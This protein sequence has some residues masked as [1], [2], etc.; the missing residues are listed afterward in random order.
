M[1]LGTRNTSETCTII[2]YGVPRLFALPRREGGRPGAR[3]LS[4]CLCVC[5]A[6]LLVI[7]LPLF[8][9]SFSLYLAWQ[10]IY[11]FIGLFLSVS[12]S[13]SLLPLPLFHPLSLP[14]PS[15]SLSFSLLRSIFFLSPYSLRLLLFRHR[16]PFIPVFPFSGFLFLCHAFFSLFLTIRSFSPLTCP[17]PSALRASRNGSRLPEKERGEEEERKR[18]R[19]I[20][21]EKEEER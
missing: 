1:Q 6:S 4:V 21:G 15:H 3:S 14:A 11:L 16:P 13:L 8:R 12:L 10:P 5:F 18:E 2:R 17:F 9:L 7:C 20:R 19:E